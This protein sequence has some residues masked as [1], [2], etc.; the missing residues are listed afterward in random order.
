MAEG[1]AL[2]ELSK[3]MKAFETGIIVVFL[4]G[5]ANPGV[6]EVLVA[7]PEDVEA[8]GPV[9]EGKVIRGKGP[10][11]VATKEQEVE[12]RRLIEQL[13]FVPFPMPQGP[14]APKPVP[15]EVPE[16]TAD[17][18]FA[19]PSYA[20][21]PGPD[22]FAMEE[23]PPE[24][25]KANVRMATA[26]R[27]AFKQLTAYKGLALPLMVDQLDDERPSMDFHGHW[28]RRDVGAACYWNIRY[29]LEDHPGDY[30]S[31]GYARK[32]RDGESH[33]KP[34]YESPGQL[35]PKG[36]KTWLMEN[37]ALSYTEKQLKCLRWALEEE[38]KIGASDADS[39]FSNILPLEI[40]ILQRRG[41]LGEDVRV[42][43]ERLVK[44]RTNKDVGGIPPELLPP[45]VK[46]SI[47]EGVP[48][49]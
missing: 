25:A 2:W 40:R 3:L 9:I 33:V 6:C 43:L 15:E 26:C 36:L 7:G 35:P 10:A 46:E 31:Y 16:S 32:G 24:I 23:E 18:P 37:A 19:D 41:Q 28:K 11:E 47:K 14:P 5:C 44:I 42:E 27:E 12:I 45:P 1:L 21:P 39:Y 49:D 17:D 4:L 34:Y 13:A 22:P 30:S 20:P 38:K 29:Q 48:G 8:V